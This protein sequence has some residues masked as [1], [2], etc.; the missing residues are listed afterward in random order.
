MEAIILAGGLG[1]RLRG[2]I[3]DLPK[4]LAPIAGEPFLV[5]LMRALRRRGVERFVLSTGYGAE[6]IEEVV[7]PAFEGAEVAYAR[8]Q[9][10]LGTGGAARLAMTRAKSDLVWLLNGDTYCEVDM[11]GA[12][13]RHRDAGASL[14]MSVRHVEDTSRFGRVEIE[15]DHAIRFDEKGQ[16]GPGWIN[17]GSYLLDRNVVDDFP[18]APAFSLEQDW[19]MPRCEAVAPLVVPAEGYFIDIGVPESYARAERELPSRVAALLESGDVN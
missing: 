15:N 18:P 19:L 13:K 3:G 2:A 9:E 10:P 6:R 17:A 8:E 5:W 1:T 11:R 4:P 14:T 12:E 16:A 7:G